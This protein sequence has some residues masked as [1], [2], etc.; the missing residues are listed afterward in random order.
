MPGYCRFWLERLRPI[1]NWLLLFVLT[2]FP[3]VQTQASENETL[4][5]GVFA[6][7]PKDIL[8]QAY[9]PLAA[10]LSE[11]LKDAQIQLHI[12]GHD[13]IENALAEKQLDLLFTN[14]SHYMVLRS[15]NTLSGALATLIS[16]ENGQ[17]TYR[18]GGVIFTRADQNSIRTLTDIKGQQIAVPGTKYLGGYQTQAFELLQAGIRLP[19]DAQVR[20]FGSHDAVV[21][22][23]LAGEADAGFI[24]TSIIEHMAAEGL[25]DPNQ[26]NIINA[27]SF[28]E[29]PYAVST[30][31]YPEW[32]FVALPHVDG[33]HVRKIAAALLAL[34]EHH[35]V[36][37][38]AGIGGFAPPADYVP[39]DN[40]AYALRLPPYDQPQKIA[41]RDIWAQHNLLI[42]VV[43][44]FVVLTLLLTM[45]I[46]R[47]NHA[48]AAFSAQQQRERLSL[49]N[50]IWGTGT[51]T[52]EWNVQTGETRFNE[53]W[54]QIVG[55]T[56][57]ELLPISIATWERFAHPE[58]LARSGEALRRHF[59]GETDHYECE[60]RM[61]HKDGRWIWVLDR[62]RIISR[63]PNGD[64]LW[65]AGTHLDITERKNTETALRQSEEY[66][67][68]V[69]SVLAEG[70]LILDREGL[71]VECNPAAAR[72]LEL[73]PDKI[74]GQRFENLYTEVYDPDGRPYP[75][76]RYPV[77]RSLRDG[78]PRHDDLMVIRKLSGETIWLS[79][80]T[81]PVHDTKEPYSGSSVMAVV[82]SFSD[83]TL[84]R[85]QQQQLE[86][87]AHYDTLTQL[88]NRTLFTDRLRQAMAQ[89]K[90]R[91]LLLALVYIDLDGFK[92]INDEYG[93]EM[94]DHLL[95]TL[96]ERMQEVL[97]EI[98]TV[99]RMGGDEFVAIL[100]DLPDRNTALM[101]VKRLLDACSRAVDIHGLQL[102]ISCSIGIS[103][104]PQSPCVEGDRL[105]SQAD[106]AMYQA[107]QA[108]KNR[109][110]VFGQSSDSSFHQTTETAYLP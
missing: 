10:Y 14:P 75:V 4:H 99:A 72:I 40:L 64:P 38:A 58:D 23:V 65:L 84:Q 103:F 107:K 77:M 39:I 52:W 8:E 47:R 16:M 48:L 104:F 100:G 61:K 93:H 56:L 76:D 11:Q 33:R 5:L 54:A 34:E 18:L 9:Q 87:L 28:P 45:M 105:L 6:Y 82:T 3:T 26:L 70:I 60:A 88:P 57:E 2:L 37:I 31:L 69:V 51:G 66:Y 81:E 12:L 79:I 85:K 22:A 59:A 53:R 13:E 25:L 101:L 20:D 36:A 92:A 62:G 109:Y 78:Q 91:N 32:P 41:W 7:R 98:D 83:V 24:R 71:V 19:D 67:R 30:R 102:Q 15:K 110:I 96:A 27:Q 94:G 55:Y 89:V 44:G 97:R 42:L 90:R 63:C 49:A 21:R 74:R 95:K 1:R 86:H 29:F 50:I 108:G 17:P 35:P 106:Q 68:S 46:V 80:N 73:K 43:A